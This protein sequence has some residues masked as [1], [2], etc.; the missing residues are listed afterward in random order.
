[1]FRR[2]GIKLGHSRRLYDKVNFCC[3]C[4][5]YYPKVFLKCP[6]HGTFLRGVPRHYKV[7]NCDD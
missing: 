1:M 4:N 7:S 5:S 2:Q 6:V 3:K